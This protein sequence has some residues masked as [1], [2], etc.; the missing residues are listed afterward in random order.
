MARASKFRVVVHYTYHQHMPCL[1][2]IV[3]CALAHHV[4]SPQVSAHPY[5]GAIV[6][7]ALAHDVVSPQVSAH[8]YL[9]AIVDC[10]LDTMLSPL[11]AHPYLGAIVDCALVHHVVSPQVSAHPYLGAIV[12]CALVHHVVSPQV[13]AHPYLGACALVLLTVPL[14]T[15]LSP[16]KY[17]QVSVVSPHIHILVPLLTIALYGQFF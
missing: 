10:A 11:S 7:C 6:D 3:D 14:Y 8:P 1:L 2:A 9:G 13:S 17:K 4:V 16:H 15:M 5:L 12:D